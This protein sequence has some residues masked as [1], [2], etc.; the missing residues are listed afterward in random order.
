MGKVELEPKSMLWF[1]KKYLEKFKNR[2]EDTYGVFEELNLIKERIYLLSKIREFSPF[3]EEEMNKNCVELEFE[4]IDH[5]KDTLQ[6]S[7]KLESETISALIITFNEE[8]CIKRCI[9]SIIDK[10]D[11]I[12]IVDTGSADKTLEIIEEYKVEKIKVFKYKW[13]D[14]F[15]DARNYALEKATKQWVFFIDADEYLNDISKQE[16]SN[17]IN[18]FN[19]FP[20]KDS[21]VLSPSITNHNGDNLLTV[22]RI[23]LKESNIKYFGLVHEEPRKD[24]H[25]IGGEVFNISVDIELN[26]DGYLEEIVEQ[27]GKTT[28]NVLL[29]KKMIEMEPDNPRWK[30]F[31]IRDSGL[32]YLTPEEMESM[33]KEAILKE[34][35]KNIEFSNLKIHEFTFA[36]ID[37]L[38]GLKLSEKEYDKVQQLSHLLEDLIPNNSNSVYYATMSRIL[39]NKEEMLNMLL[40]TIAYREKNFDVQH[41]MIHSHGYHI[42]FLIG[43]LLYESGNYD[44]ALKYFNFLDD[45]FVDENILSLYRPILSLIE[46]GKI[47]S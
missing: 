38:A 47:N 21:L 3:I 23:F 42:D 13:N 11:E 28:R 40:Q 9:D 22:K 46:E 33:I 25:L 24:N 35:E 14:S 10:V 17:T 41:G 37:L 20:L 32:D 43:I 15:S 8:R 45:K 44:K 31:L 36:L 19:H 12:V 34:T 18:M 27:K 26:H 6:T 4:S 1:N 30:Y 7:L 16:L 2:L 39:K 5:C 29:L